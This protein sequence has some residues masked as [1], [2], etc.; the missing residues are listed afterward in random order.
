MGS[1]MLITP[2]SRAHAPIVGLFT[3]PG[4]VLSF[5]VRLQVH[6]GR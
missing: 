5:Q 3:G 1:T 4:G 6:R 2:V